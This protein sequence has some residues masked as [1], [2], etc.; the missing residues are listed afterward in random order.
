MAKIIFLGFIF[1]EMILNFSKKKIVVAGTLAIARQVVAAGH[2]M[3]AAGAG[4]IFAYF[5]AR[6]A[7]GRAL[8]AAALPGVA[9]SLDVTGIGTGR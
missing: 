6:R 2:G 9:L 3:D 4:Q 8:S 7:C 1:K 5:C